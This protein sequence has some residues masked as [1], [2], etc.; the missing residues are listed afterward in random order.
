MVD[1]QRPMVVAL[2]LKPSLSCRSAVRARDQLTFEFGQTTDVGRQHAALIIMDSPCDGGLSALN[3]GFRQHRTSRHKVSRSY[4]PT[5]GLRRCNMIGETLALSHRS[6]LDLGCK[7][8]DRLAA[9][10]PKS[11]RVFVQ[12]A[13]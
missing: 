7:E 3:V 12:A 10:S 5:A 9:V 2:T 6:S 11:N 8:K 13:A 1:Q 4:V